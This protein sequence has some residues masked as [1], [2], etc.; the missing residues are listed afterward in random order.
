MESAILLPEYDQSDESKNES[1]GILYKDESG[2]LLWKNVEGEQKICI[3][4]QD[5]APTIAVAWKDV[6]FTTPDGKK[7]IDGA[8]GCVN[9][10]EIMGI[11]GPSGAGKS[12]LLS[13][14]SGQAVGKL[15][16]QVSIKGIYN[17][18]KLRDVMGFVW[19]DNIRSRNLSVSEVLEFY[20]RIKPPLDLMAPNKPIT[21]RQILR[22]QD[23]IIDGLSLG[24]VLNSLVQSLSGGELKRLSIGIELCSDPKLLIMDEPTSGLS[25]SDALFLMENVSNIALE[26]H[27]SVM[28]T[29]HQPRQQIFDQFANILLLTDG[30]VVYF[31]SPRVVRLYFEQFYRIDEQVATADAVIDILTYAATVSQNA[32]SYDD[33][34]IISFTSAA[35]SI[36]EPRENA[37]IEEMARVCAMSCK[38]QVDQVFNH[39]ELKVPVSSLHCQNKYRIDLFRRI[40]LLTWRASLMDYKTI[41]TSFMRILTTLIVATFFRAL[42]GSYLDVYNTVMALAFMTGYLSTLMFPSMENMIIDHDQFKRDYGSSKYDVFG[43]TIG[44]ALSQLPT[45]ILCVLAFIPLMYF[46]LKLRTSGGHFMYGLV[47][48]FIEV[49]ISGAL[50]QLCASLTRMPGK[51]FALAS[52]IFLSFLMVM[53]PTV[54]PSRIP[55]FLKPL[56]YISFARMCWQSLMMNEFQGMDAPC[57]IAPVEEQINYDTQMCKCSGRD[58]LVVCSEQALDLLD[59]KQVMSKFDVNPSFKIWNIVFMILVVVAFRAMQCW[60]LSKS[61]VSTGDRWKIFKKNFKEKY[62]VSA[63]RTLCMFVMLCLVTFLVTVIT[64]QIVQ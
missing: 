3:P 29:I 1:T 2:G 60:L 36:P 45:D 19:Q 34:P 62:G 24:K 52:T 14:L 47:V 17:V 6:Y 7:L 44:T 23:E 15:Q 30:E 26:Q 49:Q 55:V 33:M 40:Q 18:Q 8:F 46:G 28:M 41:G 9:S 21:K 35:S 25:S 5:K 13:I 20:I 10:Q 12:T 58:E 43:Y 50:A 22:K 54:I 37:T 32:I 48:S 31:G 38:D 11:L 39:G 59:G 53:G 61:M 51:A 16:G 63:F 4:G 27:V 57:K 42:Y 64:T 56:Y